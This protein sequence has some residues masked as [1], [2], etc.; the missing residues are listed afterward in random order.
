MRSFESLTFMEEFSRYHTSRDEDEDD[1]E[2][3]DD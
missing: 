2:E 3:D 1:E